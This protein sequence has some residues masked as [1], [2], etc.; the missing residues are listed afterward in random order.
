VE[1]AS[2]RRAS[3]EGG[4]AFP[5]RNTFIHYGT[6]LRRTSAGGRAS[7][8]TVPPDFAPEADIPWANDLQAMPPFGFQSGGIPLLLGSPMPNTGGRPQPGAGG[9]GGGAHNPAERALLASGGPP[10]PSAGS[11]AAPAARAGIAPQ[12]GGGE[13]DGGAP[14][15]RGVGIAPLRLFDFL[16]SPTPTLQVPPPPAPPTLPQTAMPHQPTAGAGMQQP[17]WQRLDGTLPMPVAAS[18]GAMGGAYAAAPPPPPFCGLPPEGGLQ[19]P[20]WSPWGAGGPCVPTVAPG[21]MAGN[22][23]TT[24]GMGGCAPH[25]AAAVHGVGC[26]IGYSAPMVAP[27]PV[28]APS[29]MVVPT[30]KP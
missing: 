13:G 3:E 14:P 28:A 27:V 8:Q 9:G 17:L 22:S 25:A 15:T 26:G 7:P 16:P 1:V 23:M 20:T 5:V 21:V 4:G 19:A 30:T 2:P 10:S 6:P 24:V 18:S 29:S 11:A 12:G